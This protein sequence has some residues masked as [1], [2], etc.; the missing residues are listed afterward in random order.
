MMLPYVIPE[1]SALF[2]AP[3]LGLSGISYGY[4]RDSGL[5]S[6]GMTNCFILLQAGQGMLESGILQKIYEF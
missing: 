6:A 4:D 1:I 3:L 5:E 2:A